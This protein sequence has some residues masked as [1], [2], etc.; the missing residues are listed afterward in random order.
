[1]EKFGRNWNTQGKYV[2]NASNAKDDWQEE[3]LEGDEV[4]EELVSL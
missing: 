1:M 4:W 2:G 3:A